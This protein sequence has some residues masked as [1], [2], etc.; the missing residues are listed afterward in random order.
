MPTPEWK[1]FY[2]TDRLWW[3]ILPAFGGTLLNGATGE[4]IDFLGLLFAAV[5][6]AGT[7]F[8][9]WRATALRVELSE[10]AL[11][12]KG[13]VAEF[14]VDLSNIYAVHETR[15]HLTVFR[16]PML[17][18]LRTRFLTFLPFGTVIAVELRRPMHYRIRVWPGY[19]WILF[20]PER[21]DELL[22]EMEAAGVQVF[23]PPDRVPSV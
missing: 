15:A 9:A 2:L 18:R 12:F 6:I 7:G 11:N 20:K 21:R 10:K 19:L 8:V 17:R 16:Q 3:W 1:V 5:W 14:T 22:S 4:G 23:R 13:G